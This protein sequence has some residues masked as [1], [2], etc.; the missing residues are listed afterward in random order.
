MH[1]WEV[2]CIGI[3]DDSEYEDT[4]Q[5]NEIGIKV[6]ENLQVHSVGKIAIQ[7]NSNNTAYHMKQGDEKIP[8][9]GSVDGAKQYIHT[10]PEFR[11]DDPLLTL[12]TITE[13][14]KADRF[15]R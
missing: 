4:R 7:L 10:L 15:T 12:P 8:L 1:S 3:D 9:Q 5:I 6:A 2:L 11:D 13:Y 14:Q